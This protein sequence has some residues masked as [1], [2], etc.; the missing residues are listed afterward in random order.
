[1]EFAVSREGTTLI[2]LHGG[3]DT[4]AREE[5]TEQLAAALEHL[6]AEGTVSAWEI[7]DASVYEQPTAPF[8]PYTITLEFSITV[9][10]EADDAD[11]ATAIGANAIDDV[12][13]Q[14]DVTPITYTSSPAA[15]AD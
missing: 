3:S 5:A 13:E 9:V 4:T 10:V 14:A 12:L 8:D 6:E 11:E 1:M 2:T 15:S 7:D